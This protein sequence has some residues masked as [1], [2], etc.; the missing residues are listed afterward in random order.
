MSP[1]EALANKKELSKEE[2]QAVLRWM[3]EEERR[4][5]VKEAAPPSQEEDVEKNW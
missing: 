2:A 5:R 3:D 1:Q 4:A